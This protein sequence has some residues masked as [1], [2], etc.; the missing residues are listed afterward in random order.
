MKILLLILIAYLLGS[1][2]TAL[3]W[4][5][6]LPISIFVSMALE[7]LEQSNT[8][9]VLGKTSGTTTFGGYVQGHLAVLLP[10]CL[11]LQRFHLLSLFLQ[12][13][14]MFFSN[15]CWI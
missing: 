11:V 5:T 15:L 3:D 1:I 14:D 10:I 2:Q 9:R 12:L 4:E 7:I 8:F 6:I 13:S